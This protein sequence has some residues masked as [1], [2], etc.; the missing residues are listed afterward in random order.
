MS[1]HDNPT[2]GLDVPA[3]I[4]GDV[5]HG[6]KVDLGELAIDHPLEEMRAQFEVPLPP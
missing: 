5:Q 4:D 6:A 3:Q 1:R 2:P